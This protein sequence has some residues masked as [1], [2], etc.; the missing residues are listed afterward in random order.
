MILTDQT[1]PDFLDRLDRAW[2][3]GTES[4]A[5]LPAQFDLGPDWVARALDH[6]PAELRRDH[7]LLTT[8]GS[9]GAPQLLVASRARAE[10]MADA[11]AQRQ[12]VTRSHTAI[13]TLPLSYCFSFVNQWV[14]A[15]RLGI[16]VV[17]AGFSDPVD[18]A[19]VWSDT[20]RGML[21]LVAAQVPLLAA[22]GQAQFPKIE[23]VAFAG[24]PFPWGQAAVLAQRFP[25]A[26]FFD[27]YGCAEAMPRLTVREVTAEVFAGEVPRP[28]RLGPPLPGITLGTSKDAEL[29]FQSPY[30]ALGA[31]TPDGYEA[32]STDAWIGTG[33]SASCDAAG[34]W[35]LGGR[36][37][38]V[39]KR[40]GEKVSLLRLRATIEGVWTNPFA[41]RPAR[42]RSGEPGVQLLLAGEA[43]RA[44]ARQVLQRIRAAHPRAHWPLQILRVERL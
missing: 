13:V 11:I 8:S 16:K 28:G 19:R 43:D 38:E 31:A 5:L 12:D 1:T 22:M 23:T 30:A 26:R 4:F 40:H 35:W 14:L 39:F 42:D 44:Q 37:A 20:D 2:Q 34:Q 29:M 9:T 33:D 36:L 7:V 17:L 21:C 41:L 3:P 27:N 25:E 15:R 10:A 24:S 18:L 32:F 6:L